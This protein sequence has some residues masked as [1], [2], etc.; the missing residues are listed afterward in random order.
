MTM[1]RKSFDIFLKLF[2]KS[3]LIFG[4]KNKE[5]MLAYMYE[6][7]SPIKKMNIENNEVLFYYPG[8]TPLWRA[9][10]ILTK[11]PDTI[12]WIKSFD[13]D[14]VFLDI[15]ANIGVF[16]IYAAIKHKMTVYSFEPDASNYYVLNKNIEINKLDYFISAY[17]IALSNKN[18]FE[19]LY[20]ENTRAGGAIKEYRDSKVSTIKCGNLLK[21]C[22]YRQ[23]A[24]GFT[25]DYIFSNFNL[26]IPNYIK[27]DV[28]GIENKIIEG[29]LNT[30]KNQTI[31]SIVVELDTSE[32]SCKEVVENIESTG[33]KLKAISHGPNA[34]NSAF[35][36]IY[37]H[38]FHRS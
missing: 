31:K 23:G 3:D 22:N 5:Y 38:F 4:K 14:A 15:G 24:F 32:K 25:I 11:D 2:E 6:N 1:L 33:L 26:A 28:D 19:Y 30:L 35:A 12:E 10:T 21:Q 37:N 16:S 36:S 13:D 29:A 34:D 9:N 20:M 8:F 27:I 18:S 7:L 17:C